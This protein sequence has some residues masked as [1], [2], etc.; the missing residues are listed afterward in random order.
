MEKDQ[1][2]IPFPDYL[3][4]HQDFDRNSYRCGYGKSTMLKNVEVFIVKVDKKWNALMV[5]KRHTA[6]IQPDGNPD[7]KEFRKQLVEDFREEGYYPRIRHLDNTGL[8]FSRDEKLN[9]DIE[10]L[11]AMKKF[12]EGR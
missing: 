12:N 11:T 4:E 10:K 1:L 2:N 5:G 9:E 6:I 8:E 3:P 7:I